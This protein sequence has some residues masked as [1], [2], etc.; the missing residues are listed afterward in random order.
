MIANS[1]PSASVLIDVK[2]KKFV[3]DFEKAEW[4]AIKAVFGNDID[5]QGCSFH[6]KVM[7]IDIH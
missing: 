7:I 1:T 2:V 4:K 3:M 5:I 6:F